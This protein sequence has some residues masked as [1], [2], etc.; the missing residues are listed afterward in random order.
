LRCAA[1]LR[2]RGQVTIGIALSLFEASQNPR[3]PRHSYHLAT[4]EG[5][6]LQP[7]RVNSSI[8]FGDVWSNAT[9]WISGELDE[10]IASSRRTQD[11]SPE[12]ESRASENT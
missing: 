1:S 3:N 12:T 7:A 8:E 9:R 4:G 2:H 11:I 6:R 10:P 5:R